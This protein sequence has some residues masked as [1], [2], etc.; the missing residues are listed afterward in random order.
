MLVCRC[1][2]VST[3]IIQKMGS[4]T[5]VDQ[6]QRLISVDPYTT[7][8]TA[9]LR[10]NTDPYTTSDTADLRENMDPSTT[11]DTADLREDVVIYNDM[12]PQ[13]WHSDEFCR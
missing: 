2:S 7:S 4:I 12:G 9:D 10:E 8:D 1:V 11:S 6:R 13:Y 3:H 5:S